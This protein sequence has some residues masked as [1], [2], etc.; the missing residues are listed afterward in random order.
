MRIAVVGAGAMG[1]IFGGTMSEAGH[2]VTLID[3]W[4]EH[5][6]A[7]NARGLRLTGVSGDRT[8]PVHAV[9]SPAGLPVQDVVIVFVKSAFTE[10]AVRQAA[11]LI[12]PETTVLTLQNGLGNADKIGAIVG[13]EKVVAGV[14]S[15]GGTMLGPGEVRH[16]GRGE[17]VLGELR[18]GLTPRLERLA[19]AFTAAG[20]EARAVENVDSLVWSKLL[21]N[22]GINAVTAV[23]RVANG[24][25][26]K[27]E[28][29]RELVR[30]AVEEGARV[31]AAKGIKLIHADPVANCLKVAELTGPNLSSMHQDVRAKRRT[32]VDVINGAIVA[33]GEKL[34]I[35][36]PVNKVLT[37]L[38]KAIEATY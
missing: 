22:V 6:N 29:T 27:H 34:G 11:A 26:P 31:A 37:N 10:T 24:E 8:I 14:T 18:G 28:A 16:A 20:L 15:H 33:E 30:L 4:A 23:L 9:T 1:C 17:T 21:V 2:E 36:T 32:E 38:I 25:L 35:P 7:L 12:G 5:V 19:A 13:A 3:V